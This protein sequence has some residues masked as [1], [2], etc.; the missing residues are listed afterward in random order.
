MS[1]STFS[2]AHPT[3]R[4]HSPYLHTIQPLPPPSPKKVSFLGVQKGYLHTQD[5]IFEIGY[6]PST[7]VSPKDWIAILPAGYTQLAHFAAFKTAPAKQ[8]ICGGS[9]TTDPKDGKNIV[10]GD[11]DS[12]TRETG[13]EANRPIRVVFR[14]QET[15]VSKPRQVYLRQWSVISTQNKNM[16]FGLTSLFRGVLSRR[17]AENKWLR[18]RQL[19][20]GDLLTRMSLGNDEGFGWKRDSVKVRCF[21]HLELV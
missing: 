1:P 16:K 15:R 2:T 3:S 5:I 8:V 19:A 12:A 6:A 18:G 17:F 20:R 10:S 21:S 9:T 13:E 4:L 7:T 14:A 11:C